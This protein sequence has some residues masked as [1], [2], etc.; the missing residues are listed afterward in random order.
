[1]ASIRQIASSYA[2]EDI[3]NVDETGLFWKLAPNQGLST[4]ALPGK[5]KDK[6]RV[7]LVFCSNATGTDKVPIWMIGTARRPR[8][9]QRVNFTAMGIVW[10]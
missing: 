9:L 4:Q 5:K 10:R 6:S 2:K 1:M 8:T 7:S 3:Y